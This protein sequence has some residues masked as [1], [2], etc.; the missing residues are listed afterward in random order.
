MLGKFSENK[1]ISYYMTDRN[2]KLKLSFLAELLQDLAIDHSD[3]LGYSLKCLEGMNKGW[4]I[5]NWHIIIDSMPSYGDNVRLETWSSLCRGFS[6]ERSYDVCDATGKPV[7]RAASRWVVLDMEKRGIVRIPQGMSDDYKSGLGPAIENERYRMPKPEG[8]PVSEFEAI[9]RRSETDSNGHTNNT[10]YIA[11]ATDMV[12]SEIYN[13]YDCRDLRVV[14]KKESYMG[15]KI[16]A[17]NYIRDIEGDKEF[18]TFLVNAD[19]E[20]ILHCQV[21]AIWKK[22]N[23]E[24]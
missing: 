8:E 9:V 18:I 21:A 4:I 6:A 23:A 3:S 17:K 5:S 11:W 7:I 10:Q 16:K 20:S 15:E 2:L 19:D 22:D 13:E 24:A 12:P 1:Q 14:Y